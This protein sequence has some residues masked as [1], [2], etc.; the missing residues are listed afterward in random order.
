M[1]ARCELVS[2]FTIVHQFLDPRELD[3]GM[4]ECNGDETQTESKR[5][6]VKKREKQAVGRRRGE[7]HE[8]RGQEYG[9][10][11]QG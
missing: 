8:D 5:E 1:D 4:F 6:A 11:S 3:S 9:Y 7:E 10:L 2:R